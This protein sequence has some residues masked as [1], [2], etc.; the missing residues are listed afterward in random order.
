MREESDHQHSARG[1]ELH[2][3]LSSQSAP[4]GTGKG[5][6]SGG[7]GGSTAA[8]Q[9]EQRKKP[10]AA[11]I[12]TD[13]EAVAV[14]KRVQVGSGRLESFACRAAAALTGVFYTEDWKSMPW[15]ET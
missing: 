4:C 7:K 9:P 15:T 1:T 6:S 14:E 8:P 11:P 10:A 13:E 3:H 12:K 5:G 2:G